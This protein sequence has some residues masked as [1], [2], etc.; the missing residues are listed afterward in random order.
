MSMNKKL[1][2]GAIAG[3]LVSANAG[4]VV[5]GTDPARRYAAEMEKPV[6]LTDAA[7]TAQFELGYNFSPSEVR[8]GRFECTANIEIDNPVVTSGSADVAVGAV[9]GAGTPAIFF[10]LTADPGLATATDAI[11]MDVDADNS[12]LDNG[13]VNC[14][15]SIYDQPSQAQ[16]GGSAGRIYTTGYQPFIVSVP[17]FEFVSDGGQAIADVEAVN[18]AYTDFLFGDGYFGHLDFSLVAAPPYIADGSVVTFADLFDAATSIDVEGDFSAA[19]DV[20][21]D[22]YGSADAFDDEMATFDIGANENDDLLWYDADLTNQIQES[23]YNATLNAVAN[24]GY[25]IDNVGPIAVGEIIRNG[26]QLQA[27]LAQVPGGWISRIA[28]TNTGSLDRAYE[29]SVFGE[30]G[31]TISTGAAALT[32]TVP[33]NGTKVIEVPDVL[34]GFTGGLPRATINVTVA[35]PNNQIQGL[36]QIVNP[37]SMSISNHV[38]VRPGT[39]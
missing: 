9:N 15:F 29:I 4:A 7:D 14:A 10:S 30:T 3:L 28:L 38:M 6:A 17:S 23:D 16:A 37:E 5:L 13:A 33:A 21:W 8:Y 2:A 25:V 22:G 27:P 32:G 1:L 11:V 34:T 18:G 12:L 31:T 26:T 19:A 20:I 36:Y 24:A 39:N 35:G